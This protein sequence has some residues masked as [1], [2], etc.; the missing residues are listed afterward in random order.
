MKGIWIT[1]EIQRRNYGISS[2]LG[3]PLFELNF[4]DDHTPIRYLKCIV[5]T[6]KILRRERPEI[7]VAQNPSMVLT[8]LGIIFKKFF[9]YKLTIDSHN[10]GIYPFEAKF[11]LLMV[12]SKWIQRHS[13][14]T[15]VT[16]PRLY[17]FVISNG[18]NPC[19]LPDKL[20][21][22][23]TPSP[24]Q[25]K[26]R[27]VIS[28]ICTFSKD[29]PYQEVLRAAEMIDE[30]IMIYFTGNYRDKVKKNTPKNVRLTGFLPESKY[31]CLLA[32]SN[33]IMDLT[34]R[35]D[36]LVCGAYE[37][38]ALGKPLI[39]SDTNALRSYFY[40]GCVYVHPDRRSIAKGIMRAIK[41]TETLQKEAINLKSEIK[42]QWK[43]D[44]NNVISEMKATLYHTK[45]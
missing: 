35:E 24:A 44:L 29:E 16:N 7:L 1:W 20:P 43:N 38:I 40:Q 42:E 26:K 45:R 31:W 34:L 39:T 10:S 12:I 41:E 23:S 8:I 5:G 15:I 19:I 32:N 3:W 25:S 21:C 6:I 30:N 33:L 18:G 37:A 28:Y 11:R 13:D 2:A 9:G 27:I 36:C 14:L 22:I 4:V 17:K